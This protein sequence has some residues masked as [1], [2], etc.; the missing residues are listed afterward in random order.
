MD[1]LNK[2][3]IIDVCLP[4]IRKRWLGA[5]NTFPHSLKEFTAEEKASNE[6]YIS[7]VSDQFSRLIGKCPRLPIFRRKWVKN[8][9]SLLYK[10]L[11]EEPV[12]SLHE[13]L[14]SER[15]KCFIT[16]IQTL[17]KEIRKFTPDLSINDLGQAVRN[18]IVYQMFKEI[19]LDTSGFSKACY[20]YSM[21]YPY[22]DN[23]I[24]NAA[25]T[26]E[27]KARY[28]QLIHH[29]ISEGKADPICEHDEKTVYFLS[30][31]KDSYQDTDRL[32][33]SALL[34]LML[35]AQKKSLQQQQKISISAKERLNIS[36]YKGG[37]SVL[38]DRFFVKK[39]M[40]HRDIL[41]Y[42]GFGFFLQLADDLQD[43]K[44]DCSQINQTLFTLDLT[45][46]HAEKTV[47]RLFCFIRELCTS[48][49]AEN[50]TFMEFVLNN[51]YLLIIMGVYK[52]RE[53]FSK[54]YV[55]ALERFFPVSFSYLEKSGRNPL[56]SNLTEQ[57]TLYK[58]I[59]TMLNHSDMGY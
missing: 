9:Y 19:H 54:E 7:R 50:K 33:V 16:E 48:F 10:V 47:N 2:S 8:I 37:M 43:I 38:I 46:E 59:D 35:E 22:T 20:G 24:D 30:A 5:E 14:P 1:E 55:N 41:F 6:A 56:G 53:Y 36:T 21:L 4:D 52:S 28:N 12:M 51:C 45:S 18:Y 40:T 31:I 26:T 34:L 3:V 29:F 17:L 58:I 15:I 25:H 27:D 23:F 32:N 44:E 11:A 42:L 39:K 49:P 13:Y 57:E